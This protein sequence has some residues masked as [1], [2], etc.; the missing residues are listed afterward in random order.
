M[1][2]DN[3]NQLRLE[4]VDQVWFFLQIQTDNIYLGL[5]ILPLFI[6]KIIWKNFFVE[7]GIYTLSCNNVVLE[8]WKKEKAK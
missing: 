3:S 7:K 4:S 1:N 2:V 5:T 8:K 6:L